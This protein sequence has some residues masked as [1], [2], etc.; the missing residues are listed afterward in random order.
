MLTKKE[1]RK[2]YYEQHKEKLLAKR[3]E[4]GKGYR[5]EHKE[6]LAEKKK[7]YAKKNKEKIKCRQKK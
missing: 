3:R 1:A 4:Y 6:E 7:E 5:A 2:A